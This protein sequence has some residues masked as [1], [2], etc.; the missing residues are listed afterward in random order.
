MTNLQVVFSPFP[1][2]I[3]KLLSYSFFQMNTGDG[4]RPRNLR[5]RGMAAGKPLCKQTSESSWKNVEDQDG[6]LWD[7][8][9]V[10]CN[11]KVE[12]DCNFWKL[13]MISSQSYVLSFSCMPWP[14]FLSEPVFC[15]MVWVY[16]VWFPSLSSKHAHGTH[17]PKSYLLPRIWM[18]YGRC[19]YNLSPILRALESAAFV[20]VIRMTKHAD[21]FPI[22][23]WLAYQNAAGFSIVPF[24]F[25]S[26]FPVPFWFFSH[27]QPCNVD[28]GIVNQS[29]CGYFNGNRIE[30]I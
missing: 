15:N 21:V 1:G 3:S 7:F 6:F 2:D 23:F 24:H 25:V 19:I 8:P 26:R 4:S 14:S 30:H 16:A 13:L 12:S 11:E 22:P 10:S 17:A 5:R 20:H 9:G 27:R 28:P 29:Q 18:V